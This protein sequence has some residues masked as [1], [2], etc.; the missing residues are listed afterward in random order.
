MGL[1][2]VNAN[3]LIIFKLHSR[4][5]G[6]SFLNLLEVVMPKKLSQLIV[7]EVRGQTHKP[8][9]QLILL[10]HNVK[11]TV[12]SCKTLVFFQTS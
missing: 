3:A 7:V 11:V 5:R 4:A 1:V 6:L 10:R 8:R 2:Q 12:F 9:Y